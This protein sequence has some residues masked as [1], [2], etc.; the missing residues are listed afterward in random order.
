MGGVDAQPDH[1]P[2]P[3]EETQPYGDSPPVAE[4]SE[5]K[6]EAAEDNTAAAPAAPTEQSLSAYNESIEKGTCTVVAKSTCGFCLRAV[7]LLNS[8]GAQI[9]VFYVDKMPEGDDVR[10]DAMTRAEGHKTVPMIFIKGTFEGGC[11]EIVAL[12]TTGELYPK[13]GVSAPPSTCK[14]TTS[15]EE[16]PAPMPSALFYFPHTV[17]IYPVRLIALQM[18]VICV[19]CI[20]WRHQTWA[21]WVA[22]GMALDF[23]IRALAGAS[24]SI[25]G[26]FAMLVSSPLKEDLRNGPPKQFATF[27]G[28]AFSLT[29]AMFLLNGYEITGATILGALAGPAAAEAFFDFCLGCWF[30]GLMTDFGIIRSNVYQVHIDQKPYV[31]R[32]LE[33]I[34]DFD[35]KLKDIVNVRYTEPGQP[36]T[37]ADVQV[38][39]FKSDDHVRRGF[40]PIRN[41][42]IS[43]MMMPLGM[44]GL[45]LAWKKPMCG[46][47]QHTDYNHMDSYIGSRKIWMSIAYISMAFFGL[48]LTLLIV[49]LFVYPRKIYSEIIHPVK[50]NGVVAFP[51]LLCL[52]S[53]LLQADTEEL[54]DFKKA[55]FWMGAVPLKLM[56]IWKCSWLVGNRTEPGVMMTPS[57]LLPIG[58]CLLAA[59]NAGLFKGY[60]EIAWFLFALPTVLSIL[61]FGGTF[62]AS[63]GFHWS[64]ERLR[65]SIAMWST[66]LHLIMIAFRALPKS[67]TYAGAVVENVAS[68]DAFSKTMYWA[69]VTLALIFM[70]LAVPMGFI[71]RVKFDF[72]FWAVAFAADILAA[73]SIMYEYSIP[74]SDDLH[75]WGDYIAVTS[76]V[77]A[78]WINVTLL[79]NTLFW[80]TKRRWLRPNYKF[81]PLSFNKLS[82]DSLRESGAHLLRTVEGIVEQTSEDRSRARDLSRGFVGH[83]KLHLMVLDWHSHMEDTLLFRMIDSFHPMVTRDGYVQHDA[84]HAME[85]QATELLKKLERPDADHY[86]LLVQARELMRD[87][88]PFSD[89]HMDWE[90]DNLNGL[91]RKKLNVSIQRKLL[92]DIWESYASKSMEEVR[93]KVAET[94]TGWSQY[95]FT[96]MSETKSF[97]TGQL[98]RET[99]LDFPPKFP[100][101]EM[102]LHKQ[103]V[104]RVALPFLLYW[105]PMPIQKTRMA[106]TLAWAVPEHAQQVGE[107]FYRGIP[108]TMWA[109][110]AT[111]VPEIVPRG[112]PGWV[113]RL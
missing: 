5:S 17:N 92:Q 25:A 68:M 23:F 105:L 13:L 39:R 106:R 15:K 9:D 4:G 79:L 103:H 30:F 90:E 41:V 67:P 63:I 47:C 100:E 35:T 88:V 33:M 24:F 73:A 45:A 12:E 50:S 69:G 87:F 108:D 32:T 89:Q 21:A 94:Q 52:Y 78:T 83:L 49:K 98:D 82:H 93:G 95:D 59:I 97:F 102:P 38:K 112:L 85:H 96:K 57:I 31:Q 76:L 48:L 2:V 20:V 61:L 7:S 77:M 72:S 29:G 3:D 44:A 84:L 11:N 91:L 58:G 10:S 64:D 28:F 80:L 104:L 107:M 71:F 6:R 40:N 62:I 16:R 56:L 46:D 27:I 81:G 37:A 34:D 36:R 99:M 111:D 66:V 8:T 51:M 74:V 86:E 113:R 65:G 55:L 18:V 19:L 42:Q 75:L 26:A 101:E 1:E 109:V 54:A 60:Q 70:W 110:L 14:W 53:I 22:L 43:D